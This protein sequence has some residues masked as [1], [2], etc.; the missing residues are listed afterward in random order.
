[1]THP[2]DQRAIDTLRRDLDHA[3][4]MYA[5]VFALAVAQVRTIDTLQEQLADARAAWA[6]VRPEMAPD[7][8]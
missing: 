6:R 2:H 5:A 8:R 4:L 1:M 7:D 3:R